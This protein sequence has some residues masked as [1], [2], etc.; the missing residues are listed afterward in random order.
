L[1][2]A[3]TGE[4]LGAAW[5]ETDMDA[6]IWSIPADRMK[7]GVSHR[8]PLSEAA[9]AVLERMAAVPTDDQIF[10]ISESSMRRA[11]KAAGGYGTVHGLRS[12]FRNWCGEE[13]DFSNETA[14]A[15]LAHS[16]GSAVERAYRRGDAL[17]KR[18][19]LMERWA[20]FCCDQIDSGQSRN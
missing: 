13:T 6:R 1:T 7:A 3:R 18:A 16:T 2:C 14:E 20:Q 4:T 17:Q 9:M 15:A 10:A 11:L 19:R 8:V 5:G 12:S